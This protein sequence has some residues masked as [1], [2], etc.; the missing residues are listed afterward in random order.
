[1]DPLDHLPAELVS[2]IFLLCLAPGRQ[3]QGCSWMEITVSHVCQRWRRWALSTPRLWS[4]IHVQCTERTLIRVEAYL[5]RSKRA[6]LDVE[7]RIRA[8]HYEENGPE[9]VP[10]VLRQIIL[11]CHRWQRFDLRVRVRANFWGM[12]GGLF[13]NI[14]VPQLVDLYIDMCHSPDP[15]PN[16][17]PPANSFTPNIFGVG[18]AGNLRR[19]SCRVHGQGSVWTRSPR[20][21]MPPLASAE[22]LFLSFHHARSALLPFAALNKASQS[23]RHLHIQFLGTLQPKILHPPP[24]LQHLTSLWLD[25]VRNDFLLNGGVVFPALTYLVLQHMSYPKVSTVPTEA[26]RASFP[27]LKHLASTLS[28]VTQESQIEAEYISNMAWHISTLTLIETVRHP[29]DP[30]IEDLIKSSNW[31]NLKTIKFDFVRGAPIDSQRALDMVKAVMKGAKS[32]RERRGRPVELEMMRW[33]VWQLRKKF[34]ATMNEVEETFSVTEVQRVAIKWPEPHTSV[35][36]PLDFGP[37]DD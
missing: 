35:V 1:M 30:P 34:P 4:T 3:I 22:E 31:K 28:I 25:S 20:Y 7:V 24:Q 8:P 33:T 5:A 21:P 10:L 14:A 2:E 29:N 11:Q 23:L 26:V 27:V 6:P 16:A 36:S 18:S 32:L 9:L 19:V 13:S 15:E 12:Y 37:M 17:D